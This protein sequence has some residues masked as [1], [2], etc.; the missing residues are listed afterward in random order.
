MLFTRALS[1]Q[2]SQKT[3][4][5]SVFV[6]HFLVFYLLMFWRSVSHNIRSLPHVISQSFIVN[7]LTLRPF[8]NKLRVSQTQSLIANQKAIIL[9]ASSSQL[10]IYLAYHWC[11]MPK[12]YANIIFD[13]FDFL[14]TQWTIDYEA[15][16]YLTNSNERFLIDRFPISQMPKL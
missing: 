6:F 15:I 2:K 5:Q 9:V 10:G 8:T 14:Q 3:F 13:V 4:F 11:S 16:D 12:S 1:F 7:S